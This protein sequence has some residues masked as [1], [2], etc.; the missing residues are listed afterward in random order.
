MAEE[1]VLAVQGNMQFSLT[2]VFLLIAFLTPLVWK[3]LK[4][5]YPPELHNVVLLL[6]RDV[7]THAVIA[8]A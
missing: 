1:A 8:V 4:Y 6:E 3:T 2:V 7:G 5:S